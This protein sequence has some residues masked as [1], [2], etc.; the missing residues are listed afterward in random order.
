MSKLVMFSSPRNTYENP[1][2]WILDAR[3]LL[4]VLACLLHFRWYTVVPTIIVAVLLWYF[5]VRRSMNVSSSMRM[6]RSW[7]AGP[8]R[9][10]RSLSRRMLMVDYQRRGVYWRPYKERDWF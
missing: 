3:L 4:F 9:P 1:K 2:L 5:E 6:V 10:A 7:L 8:H